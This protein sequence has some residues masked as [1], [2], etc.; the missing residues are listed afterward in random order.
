MKR[1][2]QNLRE[3]AAIAE[4]YLTAHNKKLSIRDFSSKKRALSPRPKGKILDASP[5]TTEG[6]KCFSCEKFGHRASECF[7][8]VQDRN[9]RKN[10]CYRCGIIGHTLMQWE[11]GNRL[12]CGG[13]GARERASKIACAVLVRI[14][15]IAENGKLEEK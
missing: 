13:A 4:Q 1:K 12:A 15:N 8:R 5:A 2:L 3:L 7:R 9:T 6:I 14:F 10:S 11:E